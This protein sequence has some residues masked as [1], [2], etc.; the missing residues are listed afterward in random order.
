MS[1][2]VAK[3]MRNVSEEESIDFVALDES[4]YLREG[5]HRTAQLYFMVHE[6]RGTSLT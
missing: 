2:G 3:F 1:L 4:T 5:R 6:E